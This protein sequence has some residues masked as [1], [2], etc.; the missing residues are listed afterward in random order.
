ML[1]VCGT[2]L[3]GKPASQPASPPASRLGHIKL[4]RVRTNQGVSVIPLEFPEARI[5]I[6]THPVYFRFS[7]APMDGYTRCSASAVLKLTGAVL[8]PTGA[9]PEPTGNALKHFLARA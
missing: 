8:E 7:S 3:I 5:F 6:L 2:N 4:S 9:V 1:L